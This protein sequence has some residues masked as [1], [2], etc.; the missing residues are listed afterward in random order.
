MKAR[1]LL[2]IAV[3]GLILASLMIHG[4]SSVHACGGGPNDPE[5]CPEK[6][7]KEKKPTETS[8]PPTATEAVVLP[9][10]TPNAALLVPPPPSDS[11]NAEVGLPSGLLG[12]GSLP[13]ILIGLLV[14][15]LIGMLVPAVLRNRGGKEGVVVQGG[16]TVGAEGV[17]VQGGRTAGAE[18]VVVQAAGWR[19]A[20]AE[21]TGSLA[22][23]Y[24][25]VAIRTPR[26]VSRFAA[27]RSGWHSHSRPTESRSPRSSAERTRGSAERP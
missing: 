12:G 21:K 3:G 22:M 20:A 7:E 15:I 25:G 19:M 11:S 9:T 4:T 6:G 23:G 27:R 10:D 2:C 1:L 13:G 8:V 18:G 5:P 14:G 26:A 17:V 24:P 16:R